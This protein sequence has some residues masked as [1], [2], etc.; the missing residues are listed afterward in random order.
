MTSVCRGG[1]VETS[2]AAKAQGGAKGKA[3]SATP[4]QLA[5]QQVWGQYAR[6]RDAG[7]W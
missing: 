3:G 6:P 5:L 4:L 1:Q 7:G 2:K